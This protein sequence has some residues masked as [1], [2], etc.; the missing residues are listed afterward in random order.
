M[1]VLFLVAIGL[2]VVLNRSATGT[3]RSG[4][5][6]GFH[7]TEVAAEVGI[8]FVHHRPTLDAKLAN[9]EPHVAALGASVSVADVNGDGWPDLYF[10]NSRFGLANALYVA[11]EQGRS[12]IAPPR[13]GS[14]T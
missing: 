6:P 11:G 13:P 12:T 8:D 10:T 14:P 3:G 5:R 4:P 7:F 9:V 2:V 1:G